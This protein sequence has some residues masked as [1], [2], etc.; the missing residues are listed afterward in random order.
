MD[1]L[2]KSEQ[3]KNLVMIGECLK[4]FKGIRLF[5]FSA[6]TGEGADSVINTIRNSVEEFYMEYEEE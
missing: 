2:K 5:P 4:K 6:Q 1:K 3:E